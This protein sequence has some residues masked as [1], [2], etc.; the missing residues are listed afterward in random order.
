MSVASPA[1]RTSVRN[2]PDTTT[3]EAGC[4]L[5]TAHEA[6]FLP[7]LG[8]TLPILCPLLAVSGAVRRRRGHSMSDY[9]S[10][11]ASPQRSPVVPSSSRST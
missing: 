4:R 8:G 6:V 3:N 9:P 1:W 2:R 5:T 10:L 7:Q 11:S